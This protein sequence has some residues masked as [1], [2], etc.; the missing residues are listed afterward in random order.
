MN[1]SS[2]LTHARHAR[3]RGHRHR[4]HGHTFAHASSTTATTPSPD[5]ILAFDASLTSE[6]L[7]SRTHT[8]THI[9]GLAKPTRPRCQE[10]TGS[11]ATLTGLRA[12]NRV[13]PCTTGAPPRSHDTASFRPPRTSRIS[14]RPALGPTNTCTHAH[15]PSAALPSHW[16]SGTPTPPRHDHHARHGQILPWISHVPAP[17]TSRAS[18]SPCLPRRHDRS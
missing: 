7:R 13:C 4:T 15:G 5:P 17:R 6:L 18:I 2:A 10:D 11:A 8:R 9:H 3:R 1:A 14:T 12:A 16:C